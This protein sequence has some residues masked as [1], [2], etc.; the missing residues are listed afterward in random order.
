[1]MTGTP[2]VTGDGIPDIWALESAGKVRFYKPSATDTGAGTTVI[3]GGWEA[4]KAFADLAPNRMTALR[5]ARSGRVHHTR[6]ARPAR[7][8]ALPHCSAPR[9]PGRTFARYARV[10]GGQNTS[11]MP[12]A[13]TTARPPAPWL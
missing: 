1:M 7:F 11:E 13:R 6:W 3:I 8:R 9:R 2:D 10:A 12:A 4:K 5:T